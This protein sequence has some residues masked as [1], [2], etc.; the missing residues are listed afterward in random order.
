MSDTKCT[1]HRVMAMTAAKPS[2]EQIAV[3]RLPFVMFAM[4]ALSAI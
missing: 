2:E 4:K 1:S 3:M